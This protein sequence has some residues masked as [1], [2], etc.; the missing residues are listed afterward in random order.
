MQALLPPDT[1]QLS[2]AEVFRR[3]RP[4]RPRFLL[5]SMPL[6]SSKSRYSFI[7]FS[8]AAPI[9]ISAGDDALS[10][11]QKG[12]AAL[13]VLGKALAKA[14]ALTAQPGLARF[15]GGL[16]GYS[17][18]EFAGALN[19]VDGAPSSTP[20]A[21]YFAVEALLVFDHAAG[22]V[23]LLQP[24][25]S[26]DL[27]LDIEAALHAAPAPWKN[28]A[29]IGDI[30]AN[31]SE[32]EFLRRVG[33][34]QERIFAGDAYQL[35]LSIRYSAPCDIDPFDG[36]CALRIVNPS[37]YMF[38]LDFGDLAIAGASPESLV[39]LRD[40]RARLRPIAG[41]RPRG[42]SLAAD[43]AAAA[44]L[45][46]DAKERAEH[47]MLVDLARNDLGRCAV[48]GSVRVDPFM[49]IERYSHVMHLVSGVEATIAPDL[50]CFDLF[51]S[52][53][54]A[55]TLTGA[56]KRRAME[57]IAELEGEPRGVYGGAV[58]Y[59][60]TDGAMDHAIAIRTLT[61]AD[62]VC[63]FQAGAGIVADSDPALEHQE[64]I[65]KAAAMRRA[66]SLAV[67]GR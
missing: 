41:T 23:H 9:S 28:R 60:G 36:Y 22:T 39:S 17:T 3:L 6:V 19:G 63:A 38:F 45:R 64:I 53:F 20:L 37:P 24:G 40:G 4:L 65:A 44:A 52:A 47:V 54:P 29:R 7:G 26:K 5:E 11:R 14:P 35:V 34:A 33:R 1:S 49:S 46:A 51:A 42:N 10:C 58:G 66:L 25:Q 13:D 50:S 56:P 32:E 30:R 55:G 61:F 31:Q 67:T 27:Q 18:Y 48:A 16:V 15:Q 57:L 59:F 62:G 43:A 21:R 8:D 2:P 12:R